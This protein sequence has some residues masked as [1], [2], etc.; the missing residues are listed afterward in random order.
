M[1]RKS[2]ALAEIYETP[3]NLGFSGGKDSVVLK[4]FADYYGIDYV[5]HFN[6]TQIEKYKGMIRFIKT[7]YPDVCIVHPDKEYSF[8]ELMKKSGLPSIFRRWCC[9]ELKHS[10]RKLKKYSVNVMGIRGE[11]S[12]ARLERGEISVF[13]KSKRAQKKLEALRKTDRKSVV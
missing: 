6:N 2:Q 8:F 3:L 13:G 12:A 7:N 10:N 4:Y 5:A 1:L 9:E 11:E